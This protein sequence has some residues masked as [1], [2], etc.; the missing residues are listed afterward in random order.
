MPGP[1]RDIPDYTVRVSARARRVRLVVTPADGLVVVVPRGFATRRIDAI[2][3]EHTVWIARTMERTSERRAHLAALAD[4]P[5]P[6]AIEMPGIGVRWSVVLR[7]TSA[8]GVRGRVEGD[9]LTLTGQVADTRA[10]LAAI[11]RAVA[12]VA[13]E[14]LPLMLGSAEAETGWSASSVRVR[15]QRSRWGSCTSTGALSLNES[16][17]F[18]PQRLVRY[19]MVHELAHTRR[20]DHSPAFWSLVHGH[21]AAWKDHRR[22]LREAWRHVPAWSEPPRATGDADG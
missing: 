5:V 2:V 12:R 7:P 11:R 3:R 19:V 16:L 13:R 22:E 21:E 1:D 20:L 18:L 9:V 6:D 10:C 15:R 14:R 8:H 17:V 4:A